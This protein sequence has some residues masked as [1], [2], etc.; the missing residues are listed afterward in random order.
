MQ[1]RARAH[2]PLAED[3][4]DLDHGVDVV[5]RVEKGE[6]LRQHGQQDHAHGPDVDLGRLR[7]AF[8]QDFGRAEAAG[9]GAVGAAR[10]PRVVL[11]EGG[12][13]GGV[14]CG[15][16]VFDLGAAPRRGLGADAV[17]RV[18]ALAL[19]EA[20]V[21]EHALLA[22][23]VVEEVGGLDVA[24]DD[25]GFVHGFEGGEERGQVGLHVAR[26]HAAEVLT[27]VLV[28]VVGKD[29]DDL[30]LVAEGGDEGAY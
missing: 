18:G 2:P 9:A 8:E 29:G 12:D 17:G 21:D 6:A 16:G 28:L 20:E 14:L 22:V 5:A 7:R 26:V 30:V 23:D 15:V 19:G 4:G 11:G 3:G 10:G 25:A 13:G 24:V 1:Q 27:E